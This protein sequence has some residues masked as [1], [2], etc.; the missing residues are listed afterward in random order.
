VAEQMLAFGTHS[1]D[2]YI[3]VV[4]GD[5]RMDAETGF[6]LLPGW[7]YLEASLPYAY[8]SP[9]PAS[10]AMAQE[11]LGLRHALRLKHVLSFRDVFEHNYFHFFND[12]LPRIPLL[13]EAGLLEGQVVIGKRLHAQPFYR[14]VEPILRA[15]G[16]D[17]VH[18]GDHMVFAERIIYCKPR[19]YHGPYLRAVL[20]LLGE[21]RRPM[22]QQD[23]RV[24]LTRNRKDTRNR[25]IA[26]LSEVT[27]LLRS[28]D[29]E[30][31]DTAGMSVQ[32]QQVLF[33]QVR[34]LI[35]V[36]GAGATNMLFRRGSPLD[37]LELF[38]AES[39]PPHYCALATAL[40]IGYDGLCC[41]P[42]GPDGTFPVALEAL[43]AAV[44]RLLRNR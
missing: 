39:Q 21:P 4:E 32:E 5:L 26:N 36:H 17:L 13:R 25:L 31:S 1:Q 42:S 40:D 22:V 29:F 24:F 6:V 23:R 41:G 2:E 15:Q 11:R 9:P 16:L 27:E 7:R 30:V 44:L 34:H 19:P 28:H 20:D 35:F 43:E 10:M 18:Q 3:H 14:S 8:A 37:V 33:A 12:V 38:P